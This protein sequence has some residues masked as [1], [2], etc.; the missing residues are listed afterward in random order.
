ML[1]DSIV[2]IYLEQLHSQFVIVTIYKASNT[3]AFICKKIYITKL[4]SEDG[5]NGYTPNKTY[6]QVLI[7]E[8]E[9]V[10]GSITYCKKLDNKKTFPIMHWL[11]RMHKTPNGSRFIVASKACCNKQLSNIVSKVFKMIYN[12]VEVFHNK[13]HFTLAS[14]NSGLYKINSQSSI[15]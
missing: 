6:Y 12:H 10:N 15:H 3:F 7:T 9:I 4:L 11:P 1:N 13:S 14:K 5:V 2:K 8:E